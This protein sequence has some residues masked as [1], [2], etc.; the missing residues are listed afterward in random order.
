MPSDEEKDPDPVLYS[1]RR[2]VAKRLWSDR[3]IFEDGD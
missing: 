1:K 3:R 2:H